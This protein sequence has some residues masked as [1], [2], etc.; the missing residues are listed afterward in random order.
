MNQSLKTL[1]MGALLLGAPL[2]VHAADADRGT[3]DEAKAMAEKAA[4]YTEEH[5]VE[6]AKKAFNKSTAAPEFHAKDLYVFVYDTKGTV[7]AHGSKEQMIG[8]NRL[9]VPDPKGKEYIKD[10][11][12]IPSGEAAWVD[13]YFRNP[14]TNEIEEKTSYVMH[15]KKTDVLVGVGAY[16]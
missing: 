8:I 6:A 1:V 16:K 15:T 7:L 10:F 3:K 4:A 9:D 11:V 5:G 14:K 2:A 12:K 13:Y